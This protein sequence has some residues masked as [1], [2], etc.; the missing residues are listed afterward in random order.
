MTGLI[1]QTQLIKLAESDIA[2]EHI[3]T[4]NAKDLHE[5]L[6]V[7]RDFSTWIKNRI[8]KYGFVENQ[9][10][11]KI[12]ENQPP[13]NGGGEIQRLQNKIEYFISLDMAKELSMVENNE[14]GREAR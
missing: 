9:D 6:G 12:P 8:E 1:E 3:K 2:N 14:K 7:G 5:F 11:V 10:Y 13:Q 4:V